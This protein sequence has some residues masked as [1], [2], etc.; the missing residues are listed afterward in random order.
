MFVASAALVAGLAG[1]AAAGSSSVKASGTTLTIYAS[2]PTG[3]ASDPLVQD[4]LDAERLA[5]QQKQSEVTA[6]KLSLH[7]IQSS[8][9]SNNARTAIENAGAVAYLGEILPGASADSLGITN[10]QD[11]LQVTPT[12]TAL[13]LT[14]AT[15]AIPNTPDRYYESLKTYGRTF[16]RVV[17]N[18]S[19]EANAQIQEMQSLSVGKL[20]VADDGSPY[21]KAI[22]LAV[23]QAAKPPITVVSS[24]GGADAIFYGASN[25]SAAIRTFNGAA[26]SNPA[27]KLFGPSALDDDAFASGL[28]AG[29]RNVYISAPGFLPSDLPAAG[30]K[31]LSDFKAAYQRAPV[32][33]AIFGYEAMAAV[34]DVLKQAGASAND[35][36]TVVRDFLAIRNR[37]SVLGTY[38]IN[39][40]GD[41]SLAPFVF[42]RLRAGKLVPFKFVQAQG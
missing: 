42:N 32:P 27:V 34:L 35:R 37:S 1:C 16:A 7:T 31:F 24:E 22:A 26:Q 36:S 10:A 3:A 23:K 8:K 29:T 13:E 5:F 38:S 41:T 9:L 17:P 19:L 39:A 18:T 33:Q 2:T 30:Q 21:G 6:F 28:G 11:V 40:N 20:Y 4:V 12:D 25:D 14:L 15:S